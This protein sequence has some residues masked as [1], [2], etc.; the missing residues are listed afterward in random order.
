VLGEHGE[1]SSAP[2]DAEAAGCAA[3]GEKEKVRSFCDFE[4][5]FEGYFHGEL[6]PAEELALQKHLQSCPTCPTRIEAYY[7]LHSVLKGYRRPLPPTALRQAYYQQAALSYERETF[8]Q[9]FK[10]L[11]YRLTSSRSPAFR[12]AQLLMLVLTGLIAGW[13]LF[14]SPEPKLYI[15]PPS[16]PSLSSPVSQEEINYV[17]YYLLA[18]E[19]ILLD[20]ENSMEKTEIYLDRELAQTLLIKTFRVHEIALQIN[21]LQL[22]NFVSQMQLLLHQISNINPS[23]ISDYID[24]IKMVIK[25]AKLL[26]NVKILERTFKNFHPQAGT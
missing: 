6:S 21:N 14:S 18:S 13:I 11:L 24:T 16:S 2:G 19:M 5:Y 23:E 1:N 3:Q 10:L 7:S 9:R 17:Y 15:P 22:L 8:T 20:I 26:S 12:F 4:I 25:E